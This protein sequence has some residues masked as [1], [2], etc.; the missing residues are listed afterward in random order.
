MNDFED[1]T[2]YYQEEKLDKFYSNSGY[3]YNFIF[4]DGSNYTY[5]KYG[6]GYNAFE[7]GL[8]WLRRQEHIC[9]GGE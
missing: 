2:I 9:D 7:C 8:E 1:L 5:D 4:E 3:Y 6:N